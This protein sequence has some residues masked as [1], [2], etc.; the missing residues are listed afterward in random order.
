MTFDNFAKDKIKSEENMYGV[1]GA[2]HIE[3]LGPMNPECEHIVAGMA[4]YNLKKVACNHCTGA[5]AVQRMIE[6]GY[7]VV[8]GTARFG[9]QSDLYVG[10]GDEVF[11][12]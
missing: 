2:V 10:N 1:Y 11:F 8:R 4:K 9:S 3:P 7:P 5:V 12:C 6:L